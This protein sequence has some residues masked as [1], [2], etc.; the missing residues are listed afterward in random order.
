[1]NP[2]QYSAKTAF[3]VLFG[4]ISTSLW[5]G[6]PFQTD[7]PDPVDF[8]HYEVYVFGG[9]DQT[10]LESDPVGPAFEANWGAVPNIQL[11]I[12]VPLGAAI[13]SNNPEHFP[14]GMGPSA[15]GIQ[16]IELGS[17]IRF[18]KETRRRPEFGIYPMVEVPTGSLAKGLGVGTAWYKLPLWVQ[19]SW[20][21]WTSY[22]GAGYQITPQTG[23][24]NFA[25]GGWL[26][27]RDVG[28]RF[29]LG[30]EIYS[31]G[32]EGII[33]PHTR[34]STLFDFGGM[35]YIHK[36]GLQILF[37]YGHSVFGQSENY[38]YLG[39]YHTWGSEKGK[40]LNG[41]LARHL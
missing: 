4:L 40:G 35:Y 13:P 3:L 9:W 32:G 10:A 25:Y 37:A 21:K 31:H 6:P 8:R 27:Q 20:G 36:P 2:T 33:T 14:L 5:A 11:H 41:F 29:T 17:K 7:D 15:F 22:G 23:F 26:L 30:G 38:A 19:K 16:D 24:R 39:L 34:S 1:L 18:V 28:K 12:I